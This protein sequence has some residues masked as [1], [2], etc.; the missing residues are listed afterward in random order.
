MFEHSIARDHLVAAAVALNEAEAVARQMLDDGG[1][2]SAT[3]YWWKQRLSELSDN[4]QR[5]ERVNLNDGW[6][7]RL[8]SVDVIREVSVVRRSVARIT[9]RSW[10]R[11]DGLEHVIACVREIDAML[12]LVGLCAL[13]LREV[14]YLT[15]LYEAAFTQVPGGVNES[16]S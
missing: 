1:S 16:A 6:E 2:I 10:T 8:V 13:S 4:R 3:A 9:G 12:A 7:S 11:A 5:L 15:P 14:V